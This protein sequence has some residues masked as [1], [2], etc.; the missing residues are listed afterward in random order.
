MNGLPDISIIVA[1]ARNR[2][3]GADNAMP[4]HL[5]ADLKRFRTLTLGKPVLMGR[6]THE[7][8]GRILPGRQNIILTRSPDF[9]APGCTIVH[10]LGELATVCAGTPELMVIGGSALY[11]ALLPRARRLYL[12][13]I[14]HD[15]PGDTY[16]PEFAAADWREISREDVRNDPDFPW[17]YSYLVL[18]RPSPEARCQ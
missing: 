16:F 17:P 3:I 11:E 14:D 1:M 8:I 7:S 15:Y 9:S 5:S 4:W 18:E 6:K 12:T 13:L 2:V 10:D